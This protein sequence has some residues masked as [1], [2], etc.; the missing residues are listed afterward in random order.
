MAESECIKD[1]YT[2]VIYWSSILRKSLQINPTLHTTFLTY[3]NLRELFIQVYIK[4]VHEESSQFDGQEAFNL[5]LF[6]IFDKLRASEDK[7]L[8]TDMFKFIFEELIF[9]ALRTPE[10]AFIIL[11]WIGD[12]FD[13]FD[14]KEDL[15]CDINV[16]NIIIKLVD[17]IKNC[18]RSL[19]HTQSIKI[20]ACFFILDRYLL[21]N[22][23]KE[24]FDFFGQDQGLIAEILNEGIF[25]VPSYDGQDGPKY[26]SK[27]LKATAF[28][29]LALLGETQRNFNTIT[30][31]LL[32]I[33]QAGVWRSAKETSWNLTANIKRRSHKYAGLVNLGCSKNLIRFYTYL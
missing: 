3:P 17:F 8:G 19:K 18:E 11:R 16:F 20:E 24:T 15:G 21:N 32:P 25:K 13:K 6:S 9:L 30:S 29:T 31:I 1:Q 5:L 10:P 23:S 7:Q 4:S 22:R 2:L 12:F 28:S 26:Q 33:H 14:L 27:E